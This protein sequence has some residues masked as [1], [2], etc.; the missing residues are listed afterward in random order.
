MDKYMKRN[1]ES[2]SQEVIQPFVSLCSIHEEQKPVTSREKQPVI[3]PIQTRGFLTHLQ[4]DLM[5]LKNLPCTCA[6]HRKQTELD[7]PHD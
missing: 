1:C 4:M 5:D 6:C 7:S 3:A 2:V